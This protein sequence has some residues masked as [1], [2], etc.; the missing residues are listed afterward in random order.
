MPPQWTVR[1]Q[2]LV[3]DHGL[4]VGA[5]SQLRSL[6]ELLRDDPTAPTSV[7]DPVAAVETHVVD[8]LSALAIPELGEAGRIAD[9]GAGAGFPGLPLAIALPT[10]TMWLVDSQ[11]R[12]CAFLRSA[13]A[14]ARVENARVLCARAEEVVERDFDVVCARAVA[15]LPVLAEY[16]APLLRVGGSFVAWK[17]RR[18]RGEEAAGIAA[19]AQLGLGEPR[20][21][22]LTATR[23]AQNRHLYVYPKVRETPSGFPRRPGIARKR[24]LSA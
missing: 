23:A 11:T 2:Q 19:A 6:I 18:E 8:S 3:D 14:V 15:S 24:P 17:G 7:T 9:L 12:K 20:I 16:A 13:V 4:P 10:A 22:A 5:Q 1:L 21:V